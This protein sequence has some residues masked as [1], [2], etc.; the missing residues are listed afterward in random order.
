[1]SPGQLGSRQHTKARWCGHK[2]DQ[3]ERARV[4]PA[5]ELSAGL[6]RTD[7][8]RQR[9]GG[10]SRPE[11]DLSAAHLGPTNKQTHGTVSLTAGLLTSLGNRE[12]EGDMQCGLPPQE[13]TGPT[14]ALP[15]RSPPADSQVLLTKTS[16]YGA[17]T[18]GAWAGLPDRL[19]AAQGSGPRP[20]RSSSAPKPEKLMGWQARLRRFTR[21][22]VC[23]ALKSGT[24]TSSTVW[25]SGPANK[26]CG[27]IEVPGSPVSRDVSVGHRRLLSAPGEHWPQSPSGPS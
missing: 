11:A 26:P 22:A 1:M 16:G 27:A 8:C 4:H 23:V 14:P 19:F 20:P 6:K 13:G 5:P 24:A 3:H 12:E 15:R 7:C 17:D 18:A 25:S 9:R 10:P 21:Q 2:C